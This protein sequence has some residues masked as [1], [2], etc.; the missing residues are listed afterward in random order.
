MKELNLRNAIKLY[1]SSVNNLR[2]K[3][4]VGCSFVVVDG[5]LLGEGI[6]NSRNSVYRK[7]RV[8]A[9]WREGLVFDSCLE[10]ECL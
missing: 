9:V 1:V 5:D 2:K 8:A 10:N 7:L 3:T 6:V 4:P